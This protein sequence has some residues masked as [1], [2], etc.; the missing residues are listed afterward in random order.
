[1]A[2]RTKTFN[3]LIMVALAVLATNSHAFQSSAMKFP[4]EMLKGY[5]N[6]SVLHIDPSLVIAAFSKAPQN[7]E[8]KTYLLAYR[9]MNEQWQEI[10]HKIYPNAYNP[11]IELRRDLQ[12]HKQPI[13][14]FK[15]QFGAAAET[16]AVYGI[17][18]QTIQLLQSLESGMFEWCFSSKDKVTNL[19]AI[20]GAVTDEPKHFWWNGQ[21]FQEKKLP[22]EENK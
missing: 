22:V 20:P 1:M 13:I 12:Y 7:G 5:E 8:A 2:I 15:V 21:T 17:N 19:V 6:V 9:N 16:L 3:T 10:F 11:R 4:M 18:E 14:I